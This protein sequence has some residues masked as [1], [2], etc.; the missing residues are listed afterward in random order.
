MKLLLLEMNSAQTFPSFYLPKWSQTLIPQFW[1][2]SADS[3]S[4]D[5]QKLIKFVGV[6]ISS[7]S[8]EV[9]TIYHNNYKMV[10]W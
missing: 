4:K 1:R 2:R 6:A 8:Y 9:T 7:E 5:L 3:D 10:I